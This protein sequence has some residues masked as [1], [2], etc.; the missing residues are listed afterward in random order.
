MGPIH[1]HSFGNANVREEEVE[2]EVSQD[3]SVED[4]VTTSVREH[5]QDEVIFQDSLLLY[6]YY[7]EHYFLA[8]KV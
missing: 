2:E 4:Q 3:I 6:S 7:V 1:T 5:C 8:E